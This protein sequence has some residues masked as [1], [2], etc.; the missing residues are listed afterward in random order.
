MG[1]AKLFYYRVILRYQGYLDYLHELNQSD[2]YALQN[3][4]ELNDRVIDVLMA[5]VI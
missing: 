3:G 5:Y 2:L 4:D 1:H